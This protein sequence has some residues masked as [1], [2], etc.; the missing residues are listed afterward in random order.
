[1]AIVAKAV[2]VAIGL[3]ANNCPIDLCLRGEKGAP[4]ASSWLRNLGELESSAGCLERCPVVSL[5]GSERCFASAVLHLWLAARR[6]S[7]DF[8]SPE[9]CLDSCSHY[10]L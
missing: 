10:V 7:A 6:C 2:V 5:A 3:R 1:M 4:V 8:R 9:E